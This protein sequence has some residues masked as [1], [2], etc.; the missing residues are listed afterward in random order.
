MDSGGLSHF[1]GRNQEAVATIRTFVRDGL[2]SP[3]VSSVDANINGLLKTCDIVEALT[4]RAGGVRFRARPGP[5]GQLLCQIR[6]EAD[7]VSVCGRLSTEVP[8]QPGV[9]MGLDCWPVGGDHREHGR[10]AK[11]ALFSRC[12]GL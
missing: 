2:W 10:I 7:R 12:V 11:A 3:V 9:K 8:I 5:T 4:R 1:A 6:A